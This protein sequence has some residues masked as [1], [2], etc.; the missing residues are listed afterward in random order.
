MNDG[1]RRKILFLCTADNIG[2][3]ERVVCALARGLSALGWD[4][5]TLFP[6]TEKAAAVIEWCRAQG[7]EAE[8]H[9]AVLDAAAPHGPKDILRLMRLVKEINPNVVNVHYGDNFISLKDMIGI[10]LAGPRMRVVTV[11]HPTPW[12]ETNADKKKLTNLAA[13]LSGAITVPS[14]ATR[15]VIL[16]AGVPSEKVHVI[17]CG[18]TP[19]AHLPGRAEARERLGLPPEA[20][21]VGSLARLVAHKGIA[22]L[23]AGAAGVPDPNGE[24][25]VAVA[26]DGPERGNLES[27]A[28]SRM[29]DRA[30]FLGRVP[31]VDD[32]YASCDVFA[33]PSHLEGFGL[34]YLEA[35]FHG[36]PS[37]GGAAGA[38]PDVIEDGATGLLV[39]PGDTAAIAA[40]IRKLRDDPALRRKQGDAARERVNR[41]FTE[42]VMA[43]GF[44]KLFRL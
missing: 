20:F 36:V 22:D 8:A 6:Q 15:D 32:F 10:G 43:E 24:L 7:V 42:A 31:D 11:H 39:A 38:V 4:V 29:K 19:P 30:V 33:L 13:M 35:A 28:A 17:P 1:K 37:I 25:L 18:L 9:P 12:D 14:R 3:M 41:E 34:V 21:I 44:D 40:A 26:G 2:G 5:R 16:E 23:I 27:L